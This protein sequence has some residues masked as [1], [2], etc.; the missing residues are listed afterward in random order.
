MTQ[1]ARITSATFDPYAVRAQFPC[2]HQEVNGHPLVF[3]DSAA[4]AQKPHAVL[5]ALMHA[6]SHNYANVH[7]GVYSLSDRATQQFEAVREKVRAFINAAS[8]KEIIFTRGATEG[9]N[10]VAHS[11]GMTHLKEGDEILITALEHHANIVPWQEVAKRT[12]AKLRVAPILD[13]GA[14][15]EDAFFAMMN[16]RTKMV[17]I[18]HMSNA[19]GTILPVERIIKAAHKVGAVV[20]IDA[21]QSAVHDVLDVQR[22]DCDFLV[23][24]G[25][26][27]Y[28]PNGTG[29][30]YGKYDLLESMPPYQ[31]GGEMITNVTFEKS[32]FQAPPLRF[33]AG[34]PVI[35]E[36]IAFGAALDYLSTF[37][38]PA[39]AS[40]E[41]HLAETARE[42]IRGMSGFRIIGEAPH[43]GAIVSFTHA[44]A[45]AND[46]GF[47]LDKCGVAVRTG[48]HCAQPLMARLGVPATARASFA[49]YNTSEDVEAF[50]RGLH[51]VQKMFG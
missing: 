27:L 50:A 17:A 9:I 16:E 42:M 35:A 36:V 29:V 4:S 38:R 34:T 2:L 5:D 28:A 11:Y 6:Y 41:L 12:G 32:D 19:L 46:I 7:R 21:C 20:L 37:D 47:V 23:F 33:E 43:R 45:H 24:S 48:H 25:H 22:L 51:K 31:M 30:L 3:L 26:K 40:H 1:P 49:M 13:S 10:L 18:T 8:E 15:D 39:I 44:H 14:L